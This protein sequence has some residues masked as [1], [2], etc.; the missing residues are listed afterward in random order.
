MSRALQTTTFQSMVV[1]DHARSFVFFLYPGNEM[2]WPE[3]NID[4]LPVVGT[5]SATNIIKNFYSQK[6]R[7]LRISDYPGNTGRLFSYC[8]RTLQT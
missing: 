6:I 2:K 1:T 5:R 3:N 7:A 8:L 4:G